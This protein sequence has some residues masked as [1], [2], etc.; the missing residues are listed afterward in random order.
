MSEVDLDTDTEDDIHVI[1]AY[2]DG[3]EASYD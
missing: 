3:K 2:I 1:L